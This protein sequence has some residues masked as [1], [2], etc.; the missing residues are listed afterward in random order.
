[1]AFPS[2]HHEA[3]RASVFKTLESFAETPVLDTVDRAIAST[4]AAVHAAI[5]EFAQTWNNQHL[6]PLRTLPPELHA[7]CLRWLRPHELIAASHV[8]RDWRAIALAEPTL[9]NSFEAKAFKMSWSN[10]SDCAEALEAMFLRSR[11][12]PF[13]FSWSWGPGMSREVRD[14][15]SHSQNVQ[16]LQSL[17]IYGPNHLPVF[18]STLIDQP[19]LQLRKL[20]VTGLD[21]PVQFPDTWN[22]VTVPRLQFL[23]LGETLFPERLQAISSVTTLSLSAPLDCRYLFELFPRVENVILHNVSTS[24]LLPRELGTSVTS[25]CMTSGQSR[26]D[27]S[28]Y[29]LEQGLRWRLVSYMDIDSTN[30]LRPL[31]WFTSRIDGGWQM[32]LHVHGNLLPWV[33]VTLKKESHGRLL[34][35]MNWADFFTQATVDLLPPFTANLTS[36]TINELAHSLPLVA[37]ITLPNLRMLCL[38]LK[39]RAEIEW[40]WDTW[41]PGH[42]RQPIDVP[43]LQE[44]VLDTIRA[45]PSAPAATMLMPVVPLVFHLTGRLERL[46]V[47]GSGIATLRDADLSFAWDFCNG[48][49]LVDVEEDLTFDLPASGS[50]VGGG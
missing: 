31:E 39:D 49:R 34:L 13:D 16:R 25:Y 28:L 2:H 15:L 23:D 6:D 37:A 44:L 46:E 30:V 21:A 26:Q 48:I 38:I 17:E 33:I 1:M 42:A 10:D 32:Y 41:L 8:S 9:W 19:M 5:A 27:H 4:L 45:T 20:V 40:I 7:S 3:L 11:S 43:A 18:I 47:I 14:I 35:N 12:A 36:L 50:P 24:N 29:L 22:D